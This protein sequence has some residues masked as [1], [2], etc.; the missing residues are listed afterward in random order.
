MDS[1]ATKMATPIT[2]NGN[3]P[4]EGRVTGEVVPRPGSLWQNPSVG[5]HCLVFGGTYA[6]CSGVVTKIN[7]TL[8]TVVLDQGSPV[9]IHK[10]HLWPKGGN[11]TDSDPGVL[12]PLPPRR[13]FA[14]CADEDGGDSPRGRDRGRY[15]G[16]DHGRDMVH[17][18]DCAWE[19][20]VGRRVVVRG[21]AHSG[22]TGVVVKANRMKPT[23]MLRAGFPASIHKKHLFPVNR[24][25]GEESS[26]SPRSRRPISAA[27]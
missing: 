8:H 20:Y 4:N 3:G 13:I 12:S 22:G 25:S 5:D 10:K 21:G 17:G 14:G 26:R 24:Y 6:G 19:I 9:P 27:N 15:D 7:A 18:T 2:R 11:V 1:S 23:V 16:N